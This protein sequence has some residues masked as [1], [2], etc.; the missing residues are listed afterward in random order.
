[1]FKWEA[2]FVKEAGGAL[3]ACTGEGKCQTALHFFEIYIMYIALSPGAR[4]ILLHQINVGHGDAAFCQKMILND[5]FECRNSKP[6]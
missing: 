2:S 6:S 5:T 3:G 4:R 1:M